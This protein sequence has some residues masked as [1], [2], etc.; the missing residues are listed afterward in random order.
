LKTLEEPP[1]HV[2]FI[3]A[4]TE[5]QKILPT[6]ISRCQRFDLRRI[7]TNII[8]EHLKFIS[9]KEGIAIT[10]AAAFAIAKGAEGG[11]RDAQSM[12]D[13]LVAFCGESIEEANVLD[14]FGFNSA[15]SISQLA[16]LLLDRDNAAALEN[17]HQHGESGKDLSKLL[18]DLI[19]HFRHILVLK[20]DPESKGSEVPPELVEILRAHTEKITTGRLLKVIDLLAETDAKM[21]W[22]PNKKLHLEIAAIKAIQVL[23]ETAIEDV[24]AMVSNAAVAAGKLPSSPAE[25]QAPAAASPVPR[26]AEPAPAVKT[27]EV[28]SPSPSDE[29][30]EIPSESDP[31][32]VA[33]SPGREPITEETPPAAAEPAAA[34][35]TPSGPLSGASLWEAAHNELIA[36]RPVLSMWL[37]AAQFMRHEG[38]EFVIGYPSEQRF[39][40]ESLV[41]HEEFILEQVSKL[42]GKKVK[43]LI[44]V[45]DEL[46]PVEIEE[47]E[48]EPASQ[49]SL[50]A[51]GDGSENS[52]TAAQAAG[53]APVEEESEEEKKDD[54]SNDPLIKEAMEVFQA[55][56][57]PGNGGEN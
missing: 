32:P 36:E 8:A 28:V 31:A 3:F 13:Q 57:I 54:F 4:T 42:A 10:D 34:P 30:V 22:A 24:I 37:D 6:I 52:E 46:T 17:I 20:V 11:M 26:A 47:E 18:D 7:P 49:E 44:E 23:G 35:V 19:G 39:Y 2:K 33:E 43:L 5:A 41:H 12:L 51:A 1:P 9:E 29:R 15:E 55:R 56:V 21:K 25:E 50:E 53:A 27:V 14:I 45:C 40:R 16:G 38:D 48:E